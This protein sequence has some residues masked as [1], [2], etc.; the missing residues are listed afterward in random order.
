[1]IKNI[2][3]FILLFNSYLYGFQLYEFSKHPVSYDP[4]GSIRGKFLLKKS[5]ITF[6]K[7]Y[8]RHTNFALEKINKNP[9]F[10]ETFI[11]SPLN[12]LCDIKYNKVLTKQCVK[13]GYDMWRCLYEYCISP[14]KPKFHYVK[15]TLPEIYNNITD[16]I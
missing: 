11:F 2:F 9:N 16:A 10:G 4:D 8:K 15:I 14:S 7:I 5:V 1:M 3:T 6:N 12:N 13:Y